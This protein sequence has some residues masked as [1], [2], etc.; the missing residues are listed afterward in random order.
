MN[1]HFV[2]IGS[3]VYATCGDCEGDGVKISFEGRKTYCS[4]C[5]GLGVVHF[6]VHDV[7]TVGA[8][9]GKCEK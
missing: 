4:D 6:S 1:K 7:K 8:R 5:N 9:E 2:I 3:G